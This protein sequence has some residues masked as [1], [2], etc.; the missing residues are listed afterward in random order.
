MFDLF[1]IILDH[2]ARQRFALVWLFNTYP[3]KSFSGYEIIEYMKQDPY[4]RIL[5]RRILPFASN[6]FI[7]ESDSKTIPTFLRDRLKELIGMGAIEFSGTDVHVKKYKLGKLLLKDYSE[8]FNLKHKDDLDLM[9]QFSHS[10]AKYSELPFAYALDMLIKSSSLNFDDGEGSE[11]SFTIVDF[12]TPFIKDFKLKERIQD[13]YTAISEKQYVDLSC[14]GHYQ[15]ERDPE[16]ITLKDFMPYVLKESRGQWYVVGKCPVDA[17]FRNIAV[18]RIMDNPVFDYERQFS[19]E[20]FKPEEYWNGCAGI[21]RYGSPLTIS[22]RVRNGNVYN[23]IDYIRATPIIKGHQEVKQEG[24][25]MKVTLSKVFMGPE[26]VRIIRSFGRNNLCDITPRWLE[27]DLWET[28]NRKDITFSLALLSDTDS[29]KWK[30]QAEKQ[31]QIHSGGENSRAVMKSEKSLNKKGWYSVSL[32][33]VLVNS[34]FFYFM[35]KVK[36]GFGTARISNFNWSMLK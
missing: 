16:L 12:E 19:R 24:E 25:W 35:D 3:A 22:F 8:E 36:L 4:D 2:T 31:L 33:Y 27:E 7:T 28:E 20:S 10:L 6:P 30:C 14:S 26:L 29:M 9:A 34:T 5:T 15:A 32:K 11:D 13:L 18:N 23:N 1:D 17:E 21:T